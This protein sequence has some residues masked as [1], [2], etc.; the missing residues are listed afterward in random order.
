MK[1]AFTVLSI[2]ANWEDQSGQ[3]VVGIALPEELAEKIGGNHEGS[4]TI[5]LIKDLFNTQSGIKDDPRITGPNARLNFTSGGLRII[6]GG[7][8]NSSEQTDKT[9]EAVSK[10]ASMLNSLSFQ[11][12]SP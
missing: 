8:T 2:P 12:D 6:A 4:S 1:K 9:E 10:I 5:Q 3:K 11:P 7:I